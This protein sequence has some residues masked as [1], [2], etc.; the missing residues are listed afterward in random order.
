MVIWLEL[1]V[2]TAETAEIKISEQETFKIKINSNSSKNLGFI[3]FG[4]S[5]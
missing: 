5:D 3:F 1:S 4:A 2:L